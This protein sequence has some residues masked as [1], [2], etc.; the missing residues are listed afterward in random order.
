MNQAP[1]VWQVNAWTV[2]TTAKI[3]N[4]TN[5]FKTLHVKMGKNAVQGASL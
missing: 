2:L 1:L 3:I 5:K 4:N